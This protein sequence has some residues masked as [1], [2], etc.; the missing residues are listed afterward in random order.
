MNS[1]VQNKI[2]ELVNSSEIFVFMKGNPQTPQCGFSA[3]TV[4]IF[5]QLGKSFESFDVLSD[6]EIRQGVKEFSNW[7]TIFASLFVGSLQMI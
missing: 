5:N 7:P 6:M 4:T 2:K 3:Q 1:D